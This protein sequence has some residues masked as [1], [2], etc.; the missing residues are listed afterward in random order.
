MNLNRFRDYLDFLLAFLAIE[1]E[2]VAADKF[3]YQQ[4]AV[5]GSDTVANQTGYYLALAAG[6]LGCG[7]V[8]PKVGNLAGLLLDAV[9]QFVFARLNILK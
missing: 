4:E 8:V 6:L 5:D 3:A 7:Q 2:A 9:F 1:N